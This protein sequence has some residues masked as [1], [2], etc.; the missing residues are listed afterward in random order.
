MTCGKRI[1]ETKKDAQSALN[2]RMNGRHEVRH[3]R[4]SFLRIYRCQ[5][6]NAWHLTH[7]ERKEP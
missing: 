3:N 1:Y 7:Q 2:A 6:C 4:P 5:K